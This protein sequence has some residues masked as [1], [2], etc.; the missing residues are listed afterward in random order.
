[1]LQWCL[2]GIQLPGWTLEELLR[3][4]RARTR[5]KMGSSSGDLVIIHALLILLFV[6]KPCNIWKYMLVIDDAVSVHALQG[7]TEQE[8]CICSTACSIV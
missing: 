7:W 3:G 6:Q 1:M 8:V 4:T 2:H 5:G